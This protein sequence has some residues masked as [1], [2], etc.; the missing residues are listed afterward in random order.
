MLHWGDLEEEP[1]MPGV[2]GFC[3]WVSRDQC[4][5]TVAL[6]TVDDGGGGRRT[7]CE[8]HADELGR[9][10]SERRGFPWVR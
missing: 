2:P 6:V 10:R 8:Q 7:L 9:H 5:A 1:D 3:S 4:G